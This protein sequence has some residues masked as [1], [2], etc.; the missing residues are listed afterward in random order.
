MKRF[1]WDHISVRRKR[2]S[3][4]GARFDLTH[5]GMFDINDLIANSIGGGVGIFLVIS[6]VCQHIRRSEL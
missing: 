4:K 5:L 1:L 3:L 6:Y 2:I